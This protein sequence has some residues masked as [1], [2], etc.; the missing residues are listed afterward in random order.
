MEV[1]FNGYAFDGL[2]DAWRLG[3]IDAAIAVI[4]VTAGRQEV[5]D[6]SNIY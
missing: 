4:S 2:L 1:E 3:Q 5:V 6:F